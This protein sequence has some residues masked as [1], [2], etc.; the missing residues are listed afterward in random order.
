MGLPRQDARVSSEGAQ[1]KSSVPAPATNIS[2]TASSTPSSIQEQTGAPTPCPASISTSAKDTSTLMAFRYDRT[3]LM[4][5]IGNE[6]TQFCLSESQLKGLRK[7]DLPVPEYKKDDF[8]WYPG[9]DLWE[10]NPDV[11]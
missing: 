9:T 4:F 5:R 6:E 7:L 8:L 3:R 11:L 2:S 1:T 10:P